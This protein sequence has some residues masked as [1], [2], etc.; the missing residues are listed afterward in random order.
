MNLCNISAWPGMITKTFL[1]GFVE[2][3]VFLRT[4]LVHS[5][6]R[7]QS[8][9]GAA[10]AILPLW[11]VVLLRRSYC[12][13]STAFAVLNDFLSPSDN[14]CNKSPASVC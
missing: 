14:T 13:P 2:K 5:Q 12:P 9:K 4:G 8:P 11:T 6:N 10:V 3:V 7:M 1:A